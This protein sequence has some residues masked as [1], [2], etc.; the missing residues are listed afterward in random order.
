MFFHSELFED[1]GLLKNFK[2]LLN[3]KTKLVKH[4]PFFSINTIVSNQKSINIDLHLKLLII[5]PS[6]RMSVKTNFTLNSSCNNKLKWAHTHIYTHI[7]ATKNKTN[8]K[9]KQN[10]R[11]VGR[12][13]FR[14]NISLS[15]SSYIPIFLVVA[16]QIN[17]FPFH[18][19]YANTFHHVHHHQTWCVP[20]KCLNY[21]CFALLFVSYLFK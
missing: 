2:L 17:S 10:I 20:D 19:V 16:F 3:W 11:F 21:F 18:S 5:Y 15:P 8:W 4:F 12:K 1:S 6:I 14:T 7:P 13:I 9:I